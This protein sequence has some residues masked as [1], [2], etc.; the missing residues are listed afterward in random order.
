MAQIPAVNIRE[1]DEL[2][3]AEYWRPAATAM[4]GMLSIDQMPANSAS[5]TGTRSPR[6][7]GR[8]TAGRPSNWHRVLADLSDTLPDK[9]TL[10]SAV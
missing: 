7:L 6:V 8:I 10:R 9:K 5:L 2:G 1:L 4:L 3:E